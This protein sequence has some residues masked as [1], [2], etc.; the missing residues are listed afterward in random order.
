MKISLHG[1]ENDTDDGN[2][3]DDDQDND[4][5]D[6]DVSTWVTR[7]LFVMSVSK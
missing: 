7:M 5:G 6:G 1:K 3:D 4:I 2:K